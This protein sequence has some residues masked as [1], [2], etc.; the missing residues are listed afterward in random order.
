MK[1]EFWSLIVTMIV[2]GLTYSIV[3]FSYM[4]SKFTT[5]D[6]YKSQ[7]LRLNRIDSRLDKR[8]SAIENKLDRLI[9]S[10]GH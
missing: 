1:K 5:V 4:H 10:K 3:S 9:E 7:S 8:L 6:V 2:G